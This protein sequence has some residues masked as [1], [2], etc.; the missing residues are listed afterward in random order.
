M[1]TSTSS[2]SYSTNSTSYSKRLHKSFQ[3][4]IWSQDSAQ[5][6]LLSQKH[7]FGPEHFEMFWFDFLFF[8]F[9]PRWLVTFLKINLSSMPGNW[10]MVEKMINRIWPEDPLS[11]LSSRS[12]FFVLH[13]LKEKSDWSFMNCRENRRLLNR[14]Y[15]KYSIPS[16]E[17]LRGTVI[18]L[19]DGRQVWK[20]YPE[21]FWW[22]KK[23]CPT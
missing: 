20:D 14:I 17:D 2:P 13:S 19:E 5:S 18:S 11:T 21:L 6:L 8:F 1:Y 10:L 4:W 12:I 16:Y 9:N 3:R 23:V 7:C 22:F 15:I